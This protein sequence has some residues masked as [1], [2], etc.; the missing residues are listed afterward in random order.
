MDHSYYFS[1]SQHFPLPI[2]SQGGGISSA[3]DVYIHDDAQIAQ[4]YLPHGPE[5]GLYNSHSAYPYPPFYYGSKP[6]QTLNVSGHPHTPFHEDESDYLNL[7]GD[8][9]GSP[10]SIMS[11]LGESPSPDISNLHPSPSPSSMSYE[12]KPNIAA[13]HQSQP[14]FITRT[15][16]WPTTTP[17]PREEAHPHIPRLPNIS[18]PVPVPNLT[19]KSRGRQVPTVAAVIMRDR[20]RSF[21]CKVPGCGKCFQ[22]GEHLKRHVRSIHTNDKRKFYSRLLRLRRL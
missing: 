11:S 18:P 19:K 9:G 8:A 2:I 7:L 21:V 20:D 10:A 5:L 6:S 13:S 15:Q 22:R 12:H 17:L 16:L 1:D 14:Q 4:H 3:E